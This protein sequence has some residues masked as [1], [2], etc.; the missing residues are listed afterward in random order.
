L[1][2]SHQNRVVFTGGSLIRVALG[3]SAHN[4]DLWGLAQVL[5][6]TE[7]SD[8]TIFSGCRK[9]CHFI[10]QERIGLFSCPLICMHAQGQL[11]SLSTIH[12]SITLN[13]K[14]REYSWRIPF[15]PGTGLGIITVNRSISL[16]VRLRD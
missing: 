11:L 7:N 16:K 4:S 5:Y 15:L 9:S 1:H 6:K 12:P 14:I 8:R 10:F 3:R 2:W 13:G